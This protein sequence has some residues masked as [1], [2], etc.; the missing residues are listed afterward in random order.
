MNLPPQADP[1]SM[2]QAG[3]QPEAGQLARAEA[4]PAPAT[5][6]PTGAVTWLPPSVPVK[7]VSPTGPSNA[8]ANGQ[9]VV[10]GAPAVADDGD[11][12]EKEWV[13]KAKQIVEQTRH[14]PYKQTK[15]LHKFR[16]EY[17]KKRYNKVIEPVEE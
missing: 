6:P 5:P 15:E 11:L 8:A 7:P 16:A 9:A 3:L 2:P 13:L 1:D 4:A 17:M 10:V 12:I 14:D